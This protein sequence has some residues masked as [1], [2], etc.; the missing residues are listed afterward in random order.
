[1]VTL[2]KGATSLTGYINGGSQQATIRSD[3]FSHL[4][5]GANSGNAGV[6]LNI[7]TTSINANGIAT[8][9]FTYAIT[10]ITCP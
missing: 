9:S 2:T 8:N 3:G 10:S 7:T 4:T 5:L 6:A 1:M